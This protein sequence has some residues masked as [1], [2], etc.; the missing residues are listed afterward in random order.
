MSMPHIAG[1]SARPARDTA[2]ESSQ[3]S[4]TRSP[5]APG[6]DSKQ[7]GSERV[8]V[9]MAAI[10]AQAAEQVGYHS[11][12]GSTST[13]TAAT[14]AL[15]SARSPAR[16]VASSADAVIS[17]F[18]MSADDAGDELDS[19]RKK[20]AGRR[21]RRAAAAAGYSPAAP[22]TPVGDGDHS[23]AAR[24]VGARTPVHMHS[25]EVDSAVWGGL[26]CP[27]NAS[28][29]DTAVLVIGGNNRA[30]CF[31]PLYIACGCC[32]VAAV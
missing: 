4:S 12:G 6:S 13:S 32:V 26:S 18:K 16:A 23:P 15:N 20:D 24:S 30:H 1:A 11:G 28:A 9:D 29:G 14:T 2:A 25:S 10:R 8:R 31:T 19:G 3:F 27:L 21:G 17:P 5:V 7:R 22:A